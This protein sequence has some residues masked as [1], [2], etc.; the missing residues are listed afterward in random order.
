MKMKSN[1]VQNNH[2]GAKITIME[3]KINPSVRSAKPVA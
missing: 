3:S 1:V 2:V